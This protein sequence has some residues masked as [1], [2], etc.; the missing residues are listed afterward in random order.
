MTAGDECAGTHLDTS[1]GLGCPDRQ[2]IRHGKASRQYVLGN[3]R[4]SPLGLQGREGET[5]E[6][7]LPTSYVTPSFAATFISP[8]PNSC[9]TLRPSAKS[10][11]G[12]TCVHPRAVGSS[13]MS[14]VATAASATS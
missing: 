9:P 11:A 12:N 4:P 14:S 3:L 10:L 1:L 8:P 2:T 7:C 5:T 13:W 6:V